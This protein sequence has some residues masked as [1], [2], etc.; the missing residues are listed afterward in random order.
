MCWGHSAE[1]IKTGKSQSVAGMLQL[2]TDTQGVICMLEGSLW[3]ANLGA[4]EA[5]HRKAPKVAGQG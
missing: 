3:A 4:T 5:R 1:V 2:H